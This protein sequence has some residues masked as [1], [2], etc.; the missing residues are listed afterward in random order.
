MRK[1][2]HIRVSLNLYRTL[3]TVMPFTANKIYDYTKQPTP[4]CWRFAHAMDL[5][6]YSLAS[7]ASE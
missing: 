7:E 5:F 4:K 6:S 1:T 3:P 2:F